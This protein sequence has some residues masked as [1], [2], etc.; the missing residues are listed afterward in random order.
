MNNSE[1][2]TNIYINLN[3]KRANISYLSLLK[4]IINTGSLLIV[5]LKNG[6]DGKIYYKITQ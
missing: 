2:L 5:V 1:H 3:I 6:K 4:G